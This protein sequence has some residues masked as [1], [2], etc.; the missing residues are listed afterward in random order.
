MTSRNHKLD[1]QQIIHNTLQ[2]IMVY[3][4]GGVIYANPFCYQLFGTDEHNEDKW[5]DF[6][7]FHDLSMI[8]ETI[9]QVLVLQH[10]K[11]INHLTIKKKDGTSINV[12]AYVMPLTNQD[13]V[14]A[15]L[16]FIENGSIENKLEQRRHQYISENMQNLIC[17]HDEHGQFVNITPSVHKLIGY[18]TDELIGRSPCELIHPQDQTRVKYSFRSFLYSKEAKT[19]RFRIK[20]KMDKY[21]WVETEL[22]IIEDQTRSYIISNTKNIDKQIHAEKLAMQSEKLAMV[23]EL[24]AG[25]VHEIKNPLTSIKGFLQLM[26][27]G[28]IDMKDYVPILSAEVERMEAMTMN[29]LSFAKPQ[30]DIK[31]RCITKILDDV[32]LLME[33]HAN[34]K[35]VQIICNYSGK[36]YFVWGNESQLKQVFMNLVKNAIEASQKCSSVYVKVEEEQFHYSIKVID[37]GN[38]IPKDKLSQIGQSFYTTKD[39][40]TGL[41]LMVSYRIIDH[42]QGDIRVDSELGKGTTFIVRLPKC[43]TSTDCKEEKSDITRKKDRPVSES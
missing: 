42:H 34:K 38:G 27:A 29:M 32:I 41:G 9:H 21:L 19:V 3:G 33:V 16:Q 17:E 15:Y 2:A 28:A 37:E 30:E 39:K 18:Q 26:K 31:K 35:N 14:Y 43:Q 11:T 22:H 5:D 20:K 10:T 8:K 24:S 36:E 4:D 12:Q 1:F 13:Q 25:I 40:G 23:G 6:F 7:S